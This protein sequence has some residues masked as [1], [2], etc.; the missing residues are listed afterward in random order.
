MGQSEISFI[1][2]ALSVI[3]LSRFIRFFVNREKF[4]TTEHIFAIVGGTGSGKTA[5]MTHI[6][7]QRLKKYGK[8]KGLLIANYPIKT[9][10]KE[11]CYILNEDIFKLKARVPDNS[12]ILIDEVGAYFNRFGYKGLELESLFLRLSRQFANCT[13]IFADQRLGN[14]PINFRDKINIVYSL[15][16]FKSFFFG[17]FGSSKVKKINYNVDLFQIT[18]PEDKYSF[19]R[20]KNDYNSRMY[21]KAYNNLIPELEAQKYEGLDISDEVLKE[22]IDNIYKEINKKTIRKENK[23]LKNENKE[24][25]SNNNNN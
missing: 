24:N 18:N 7:K 19:F 5:S 3:F 13:I 16:E 12:V 25:E 6:G 23:G 21:K 2:V 14:I 15:T 1:I 9:N 11:Y 4:D 10:K 17:M 8:N 20:F 22:M